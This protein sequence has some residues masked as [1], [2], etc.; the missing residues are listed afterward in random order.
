MQIKTNSQFFSKNCQQRTTPVSC[1][2][3]T[4]NNNSI[5]VK[6]KSKQQT[7]NRDYASGA[8]ED[9]KLLGTGRTIST[10]VTAAND[11]CGSKVVA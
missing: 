5:D 7:F 2:T 1:G 9:I 3:M 4:V 10:P 6:P 11:V 8:K